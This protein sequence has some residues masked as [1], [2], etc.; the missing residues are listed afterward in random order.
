MFF[1]S[2]LKDAAGQ[3][4][5][6]RWEYNGKRVAQV[7]FQPQANHWRV[8]SSKTLMPDQTGTWTVEVLDAGGNVLLDLFDQGSEALLIDGTG[9]L[10][11]REVDPEV[12]LELLL[13][14]N[15]A[16]CRPPLEDAEVAGVVESIARLH[17]AE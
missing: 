14:W 10:L 15:R 1:F 17:R 11:W 3:S 4:I 2:V 9:H 5:T 8:W 7:Q 6:H 12:V 13:A 16:R